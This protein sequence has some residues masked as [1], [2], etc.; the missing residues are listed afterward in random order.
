[1]N[2]EFSFRQIQ[3]G[4]IAMI[5]ITLG[6]IYFVRFVM[7]RKS[8]TNLT[9]K[10]QNTRWKSPLEGHAK[11]PELD[12]FRL[13]GSF[14]NYG[15][16]LSLVI[17]IFAFGWTTFEREIDL[18]AFIGVLSDEIEMETP[19]TSEPLP[20]PMPPPPAVMQYIP[21]D[22]PITETVVFQDQSIDATSAIEAPIPVETKEIVA[23]PAPPPPPPSEAEEQEIF[24]IV[25][26]NPSFP[27]CEDVADKE[28]RYACAEEKMLQYIYKNIQ[29]PP[30]ARENNVSGL[31]VLSFVVER[32][33]SI[34]A[35]QT[36]RDIGG[37]CGE[38][39]MRVV[40]NMPKW[41]PGKQRGRPVRV[42]FT[43][44]V[45]FKLVSF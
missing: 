43:L 45:R 15:L 13:S 42:Q 9:A 23:P 31:V 41:N 20:P 21:S 12:V 7:D 4:I 3:L 28:K 18:S 32:D 27:G 5:L 25:E 24:K 2:F 11:Y 26:E 16:L 29:Y 37:G 14:Q 40:Q 33:G 10:H 22:L 44:P 39:A 17:M 34:S 8:R 6:M 1:M 30:I 35:L 38:E 36:L 19:R